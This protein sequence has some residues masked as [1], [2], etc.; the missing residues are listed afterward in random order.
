[1]VLK[2]GLTGGIGSGK[3]T[4]A[5]L[6]HGRGAAVMDADALARQST[7]AGGSAMPDIVRLFGADFLTPE[8]ALHRER[9]RAHVFQ[10]PAARQQLEAIIHPQVAMAIERALQQL[11]AP[12]VVFDIPLLVES[13]RWRPQLDWVLVVDCHPDV[14]R[15]RVRARNGWDDVTID[16][17]LQSQST[18]TRRLAAADA[19]VT[20]EGSRDEL[21]VQ[22]HR[23]APQF[24]L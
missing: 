6:L 14:Q 17:I 15:Q 8:G 16:A 22:I 10:H 1:M 12:C 7:L 13:P 24:G 20:N 23:L 19:V 18:R 2:L 9:M 21:A 4:V 11:H 5:Q 3:S